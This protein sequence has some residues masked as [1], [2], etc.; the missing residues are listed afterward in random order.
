M[1][2]QPRSACPLGATLLAKRNRAHLRTRP[3]AGQALA[4][5]LG[6]RSA[7][8]KVEPVLLRLEACGNG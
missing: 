4:L 3:C 8:L 6:R 7:V 2:V 1:A 5:F